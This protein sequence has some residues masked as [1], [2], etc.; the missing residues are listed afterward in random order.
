MAIYEDGTMDCWVVRQDDSRDRSE[1][2]MERRP[3]YVET[4]APP[5]QKC[6]PEL[7]LGEKVRWAM[8]NSIPT[9]IIDECVFASNEPPMEFR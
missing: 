9:I 1:Q 6:Q 8:G 2:R 5:D 4:T 7:R 3:F